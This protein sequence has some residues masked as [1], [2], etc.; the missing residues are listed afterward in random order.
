MANGEPGI[1]KRI[2]LYARNLQIF[3]NRYWN[4]AC[5]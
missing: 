2:E 1:H 5:G 4:P 3:D